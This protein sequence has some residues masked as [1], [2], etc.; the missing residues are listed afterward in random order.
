MPEFLDLFTSHLKSEF[1]V[2]EKSAFM[3]HMSNALKELGKI[4]RLSQ[5]RVRAHGAEDAPGPA[6]GESGKGAHMLGEGQSVPKSIVALHRSIYCSV[7]FKA[8][9]SLG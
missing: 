7:L 4:E 2:D 6:F 9:A 8:A 1:S 5:A 3:M